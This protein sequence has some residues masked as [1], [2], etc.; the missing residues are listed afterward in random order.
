M[1]DASKGSLR[2]ERHTDVAQLVPPKVWRLELDISVLDGDPDSR[3]PG[4][5]SRRIEN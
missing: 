5:P 2:S 3:L 1:N 4:G